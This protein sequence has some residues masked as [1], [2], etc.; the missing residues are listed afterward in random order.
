MT[1]EIKIKKSILFSIIGI[2]IIGVFVF[3][4]LRSVIAGK[5]NEITGE[6]VKGGSP[7]INKMFNDDD[8]QIVN[9]GVA[10]YNYDPQ[11]IKVKANKPVK[12]IGNMNQL[13]GC[14]RSFNIRDLGI[15]KVFSNNDNVLEFTPKEKG[16]HSFSCS[17]GMGYGQLIIE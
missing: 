15:S 6:L 11:T 14:L 12:I 1:E 9:L 8:M 5:N 3:F 16:T 2:L 10:N 13:K 4:A 7:G 17:M